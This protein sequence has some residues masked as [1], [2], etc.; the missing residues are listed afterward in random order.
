[1]LSFRKSVDPA[2]AVGRINHATGVSL[3]QTASQQQ[4]ANIMYTPPQNQRL[5]TANHSSIINGH[6]SIA[7]A[8][9]FSFVF[10]NRFFVLCKP[11]SE[12]T[13]T[14]CLF[15]IFIS[16]RASRMPIKCLFSGFVYTFWRENGKRHWGKLQLRGKTLSN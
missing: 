12:L 10:H 9:L 13:P 2:A 8:S 15:S 16:I 6:A 3:H 1:M 11:K 14:P 4:H 5:V 7:L